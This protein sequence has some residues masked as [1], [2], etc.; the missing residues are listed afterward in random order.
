[1][2]EQ[3]VRLLILGVAMPEQGIIAQTITAALRARNG[4]GF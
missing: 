2:E 4:I 1:M 3:V